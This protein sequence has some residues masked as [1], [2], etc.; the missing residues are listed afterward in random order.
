ML[1][2]WHEACFTYTIKSK[3]PSRQGETNPTQIG[4]FAMTRRA[5][6]SMTLVAVTLF[7]AEAFAGN[8]HSNHQRHR[9]REREHRRQ[10]DREKAFTHGQSRGNHHR[11]SGTDQNEGRFREESGYRRGRMNNYHYGSNGHGKRGYQVFPYG[12]GQGYRWHGYP[13]QI[14]YRSGIGHS[15]LNYANRG[16]YNGHYGYPSNSIYFG[17]RR[18]SIGFNF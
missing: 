15:R 7:T 6:M 14:N 16:R 13:G 5:L 3:L 18:F 10:D 8:S 2:F 12:Q 4:E 17:G 9:S 1:H 11:S